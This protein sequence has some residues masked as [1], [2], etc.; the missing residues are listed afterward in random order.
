MKADLPEKEKPAPTPEGADVV[1]KG[2][3]TRPKVSKPAPEKK[4]VLKNVSPI[5]KLPDGSGFF[6]AEIE[7]TPAPEKKTNYLDET[8]K[9]FGWGAD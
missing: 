4:P 9:T 6:T 3:E 1:K 2:K 8:F 7:T 5:T